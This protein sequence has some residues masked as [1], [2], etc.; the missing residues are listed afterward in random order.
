MI[1]AGSH[2]SSAGG[3][4]AM[5]RQIRKLG[6]DTFAFFTRNPRGARAKKLD[7]EDIREFL[8]MAGELKLG[9]VVAHAPYTLNACA[10]RE[11]LRRFARET[12]AD[13]LKR[14][15]CTPG[16]Y[17]NFHPGCHVG[18]GTEA[19]IRLIA[20]TLNGILKDEEH[21][22]VLL[23]TMSGK[24]SEVGRTFEELREILDRVERQDRIG[25]C[26][27][28]CH[29]WDAGYDIAGNP[30]GVFEEFDRVIGLDRLKALHIND[31]QNPRG[32][33][34][35][36]HAKIGEGMIGAEAVRRIVNH[37]AVQGLPCILE[38]PNDD[39]GWA[40]EIAFLRSACQYKEK[41][42][43]GEQI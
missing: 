20:E 17:Y 14:L 21:T 10:A 18:Q 32:S 5:G 1:Y 25:V 23:E 13:D 30:D 43:E 3:Y 34:K 38:T 29:V 24:G 19:G 15:S 28:I 33:R 27:D 6:G 11:D 36:R 40:R 8:E 9:P 26:L 39:E 42:M 22:T 41:N 37:P 4:A 2:I 31:S 16:N 35:D 12:M 7:P